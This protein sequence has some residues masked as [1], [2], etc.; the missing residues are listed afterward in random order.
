VNKDPRQD[1]AGVPWEGRKFDENP[2]AGDDGLSPRQ[3]AEALIA[4][5]FDKMRFLESLRNQ[6]LLIPLIAEL[7]ESEIGPHGQLVEKSADLGIVAVSTPDGKTA[8]PAFTSVA[9]MSKW[10]PESRPVPVSVEKLCLAAA[11]EG[12]ER[13][14]VNPMTDSRVVRRTQIAALAQGLNLTDVA[15]DAEISQALEFAVSGTP[16]II[17]A[18]AVDSD[19]EARLTSDEVRIEIAL[20]QGLSQQELSEVLEVFISK[21]Q[22]SAFVKKV[23]SFGLKLVSA[24]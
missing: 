1:S 21:L 6:R 17:S 10:N 20:S 18:L 24:S 15:T 13:V 12:H 8:I 2:W 9:A 19:P 23:D 22:Q 11:S 14:V 5:P 7:G 3:I 4:E 16:Q